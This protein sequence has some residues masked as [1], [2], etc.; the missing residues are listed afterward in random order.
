MTTV[1]PSD[2]LMTGRH[3][4]VFELVHFVN[5]KSIPNRNTPMTFPVLLLTTSVRPGQ[6]RGSDSCSSCW[7]SFVTADGMSHRLLLRRIMS[8]TVCIKAE[9]GHVTSEE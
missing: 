2:Q 9:C 4:H 7:L 8:V 1:P 6:D 5:Q 3:H